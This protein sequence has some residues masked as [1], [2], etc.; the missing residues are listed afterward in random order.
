MPTTVSVNTHFP[1]YEIIGELGRSNARVLKARHLATG[2]LVAIKHFTVNTDAD[3]LRRFRL[4]SQLM[5]DIQHP[6]VVRVREVQLDMPMPFIVM[7]W[8]E[9]GNLRTLLGEQGYLDIP[10]TIRLGLQMAEAFKAIHPR[11]IIHRDIKPENILFRSLPSGEIHFLLTDFGVARLREQSQTMTG[12]SLMTYEYASP[13]QFDNPRGVDEATDYYSLG[14]VLYECL[15]GKVPF[16]MTDSTGIARFMGEVLRSTPPALRL[17]SGQNVPPSLDTIL[18]WILAKSPARRLHDVNELIFLLKQAQV[19]QTQ[20]SRLSAQQPSVPS[21]TMAAHVPMSQSVAP[22]EPVADVEPY[23]RTNR[24][25]N[26]LI[27]FMVTLL[28]GLAVLY[29]NYL[30]DAK[31]KIHIVADSTR[32]TTDSSDTDVVEGD[33]TSA[34]SESPIETITDSTNT[35]TPPETVPEPPANVPDSSNVVVD[36]AAAF[37]E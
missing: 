33:T 29:K 27:F 24:W 25:L 23:I 10:N 18:E 8:V 30:D 22:V 31:T 13:E 9:G 3:T 21:R 28:I 14:V 37:N 34:S 6:N 26:G 35:E 19:E 7:E 15:S 12:Q 20:T 16:S 17:P 5:T 36:S 1:G 11:G 2:D 4:E 32:M